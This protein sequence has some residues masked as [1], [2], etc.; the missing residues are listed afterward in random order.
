MPLLLIIKGETSQY[1]NFP[2]IKAF[3]YAVS[4]NLTKNILL[5]WFYLSKIYYKFEGSVMLINLIKDENWR[6]IAL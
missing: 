5:F 4:F 6:D 2:L 3:S 1:L